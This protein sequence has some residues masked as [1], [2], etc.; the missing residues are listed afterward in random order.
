VRWLGSGPRCGI[1]EIV[2]PAT[3]PGSSI[4]PGKVNPVM[5]E[6]LL[7]AVAFTLGA[8]ATIAVCGQAGTFELNVM[9]PVMAYQLLESLRI[10]S[11]A[12]RTFTERCVLGIDADAERC[13]AGIERSLALCTA[14]APAIGYDAAAAIAKEAFAS[15]RTV[16]EVARERQVL[17]DA[18]LTRLLDPLRMTEPGVPDESKP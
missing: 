17:P 11:A 18:E 2:L 10:L 7:Q 4:M 15:G 3:Q 12:V 8:D 13:A 16:R 6:A 1:G 14:L 5:A 9:M